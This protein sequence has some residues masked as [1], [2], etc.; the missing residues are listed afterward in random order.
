M[1]LECILV[2]LVDSSQF[3]MEATFDFKSGRF[4][5]SCVVQHLFNTMHLPNIHSPSEL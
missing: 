1:L 3:Q 5:G 2:V 4:S